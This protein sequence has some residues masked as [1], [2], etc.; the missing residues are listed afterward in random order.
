MTRREWKNA[1]ARRLAGT[2]AP[3]R[4]AQMLLCH[5]LG[6]SREALAAH[7]DE[8]LEESEE[9]RLEDLLT[10]RLSGEPVAY[11]LGS[12]EFYGRDFMVSPATLIPRPETEDL[13]DEALIHFPPDSSVRF[14]DLGTG[15]GCIAVTLAAERLRWSGTALDVSPEALDLARANAQR[16]GTAERITFV[17]A[18]FSLPLPL[19]AGS[20]DLVVSNP[21]YVSEE[22]YA[23]LD[24]GVRDHEPRA[25][26]VPGPTGLELPAAAVRRAAE[27]LRPGGLLLMEHGWRQGETCRALC[28]A[29]E[30]NETGTG[31]DLAGRERFLRAVRR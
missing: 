23:V 11:V 18:D 5:A 2:D 6:M 31:R 21:P 29:E 16:H 12:R 1:A 7:D 25:A 27:L 19:P 20:F 10:R 28:R 24:A 14:A 9:A 26:L 30:W 22:E 8:A 3:A 15:S 17:Q 4:T 13:V